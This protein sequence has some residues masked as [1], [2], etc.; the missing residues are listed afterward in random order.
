MYRDKVK[1]WELLLLLIALTAL[2]Y[3][4]WFLRQETITNKLRVIDAPAMPINVTR[5]EKI[6]DPVYLSGL[7]DWESVED[8]QAFLEA[9][10]T[11]KLNLPDGYCWKYAF[12]LRDRAADLGKNIEVEL[13]DYE[14][15]SK[16]SKE[17]KLEMLYEGW[18]AID[19]A[20]IGTEIW[21]I[22]PQA[23]VCWHV[24]DLYN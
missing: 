8:L 11:D 21:Y 7:T 10:N 1:Y 14:E 19:T 16:Y 12:Q 5:V 17:I 22:E 15:Y 24:L 4:G 6:E 9:D 20:I 13:I 3:S 18:H 2:F 23:D